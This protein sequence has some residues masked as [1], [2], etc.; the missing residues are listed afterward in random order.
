M[1]RPLQEQ[2]IQD[3]TAG[4]SKSRASISS[5]AG[6]G[7]DRHRGIAPTHRIAELIQSQGEPQQVPLQPAKHEEIPRTS[8]KTNTTAVPSTAK[9]SRSGGGGN[10]CWGS[11]EGALEMETGVFQSRFGVLIGDRAPATGAEGPVCVRRVV[12]PMRIWPDVDLVADYGLHLALQ[13]SS[14]I[15]TA[16]P[17]A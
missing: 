13:H 5:E 15:S 9:L 8:M 1:P 2:D 3:R 17:L 4:S 7:G 10:H 11:M 6:P 16:D 14:Q 12:L